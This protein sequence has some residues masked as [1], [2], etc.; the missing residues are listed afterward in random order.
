MVLE[1]LKEQKTLAQ[2]SSEFELQAHQISDWKKQ[3]ISGI[4][5][6][7]GVKKSGVSDDEKEELTA[8]LYQQIGQLKVE[9]DFLKKKLRKNP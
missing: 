5:T 4:P 3:V 9:L 1:T 6:L 8:P 7:F 2:L